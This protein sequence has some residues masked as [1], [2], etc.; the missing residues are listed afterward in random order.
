MKTLQAK[1]KETPTTVT[2]LDIEFGED[3]LTASAVVERMKREA[4]AN[5][6]RNLHEKIATLSLDDIEFKIVD[7]ETRTH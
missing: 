6:R 5:I 2:K 3:W 7:F 4:L 1:L